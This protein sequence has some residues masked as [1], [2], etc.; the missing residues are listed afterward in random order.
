MARS[1]RSADHAFK[2][3]FDQRLAAEV[4]RRLLALDRA[5]DAGAIVSSKAQLVQFGHLA[6]R[7]A[8]HGTR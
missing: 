6:L 5:V 4:N 1:S 2:S 7:G 3:S 8:N